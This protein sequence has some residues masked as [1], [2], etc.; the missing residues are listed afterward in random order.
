MNEHSPAEKAESADYNSSA[1]ADPDSSVSVNSSTTAGSDSSVS[2]GSSTTADSGFST[3]VDSSAT[4]D[5]SDSLEEN[6]GIPSDQSDNL[7]SSLKLA[8]K[9]VSSAS[10]S[11][12]KS[13]PKLGFT[14]GLVSGPDKVKNSVPNV[15][16]VRPKVIRHTR[17]ILKPDCGQPGLLPGVLQNADDACDNEDFFDAEED[18][19]DDAD[20]EVMTVVTTDHV[21][22][23]MMMP[24]TPCMKPDT[25]LMKPDTPLMKPDHLLKKPVIPVKKPKFGF[26]EV[27]CLLLK[28]LILKV[29][30]PFA[31]HPGISLDLEQ[32][33]A[34]PGGER[35][36]LPA[37]GGR[38]HGEVCLQRGQ[39]CD[40]PVDAASDSE[41]SYRE[42]F[43]Q[44]DCGKSPEESV[45]VQGDDV[46]VA[47][48][49][50][51]LGE[52]AVL[53]GQGEPVLGKSDVLPGQGHGCHEWPGHADQSR[54][55]LHSGEGRT[56]K[57]F[58]PG[59]N[60]KHLSETY[61]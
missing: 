23:D 42:S 5:G 41:E 35:P 6:R 38:D 30:S 1:T 34:P 11:W 10:L 32:P 50:P 29:L 17:D 28:I 27:L 22:R 51:G 56:G 60:F 7:I 47:Q 48:G 59:G 4:A 46:G 53:A 16:V 31:C 45:S 57:T 8:I 54:H 33:A 2:V 19:G 24:N 52:P 61:I 58:D 20:N 3:S 14:M 12:L 13:F 39:G 21:H 15:A 43:L 40:G 37:P 55:V 9:R 36:V 44:F 18:I 25:P 26:F 49:E